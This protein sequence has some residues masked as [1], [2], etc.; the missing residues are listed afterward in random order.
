MNAGGYVTGAQLAM[1]GEYYAKAIHVSS[2]IAST[3]LHIL[4]Y[5]GIVKRTGK[6]GNAYLYELDR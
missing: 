3:V 4:H 5:I 1:L 6:K 2:K